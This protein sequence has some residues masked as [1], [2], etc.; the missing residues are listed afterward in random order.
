MAWARASDPE[1]ARRWTVAIIGDGG[2]TAGV[3]LEALN[4]LRALSLGPLLILLNDNQMS[5]SPNVGA[6]PAILSSGKAK[7]FFEAFDVDYIGP[8]D[9][10]DLQSLI[11]L[12]ESLKSRPPERPVILHALT[13]KG[14]G[15]LPAEE[16]PAFYHGISPI[17]QKLPESSQNSVSPSSSFSQVF[18]LALCKLAEHRPEIVAIT[19]AMPEGT[20]LTGFSQLHADRFFDVGIAEPHAVTFAAGLATQG[21]RPVVAIYSTFLQRGLDA[22]IHDVALQ[23]LPVVFAIDRAGLVGPDGPTHHGAFD[24]AYLG[25]IPGLQIYCPSVLSDVPDLLKKALDH[26]GPCAIRYPRGSA[27][28]TDSVSLTDGIRWHFQVEQP[29]AIVIALGAA[30]SKGLKV[31]ELLSPAERARCTFMSCV[32]AK[33]IPVSLIQV[34]RENP[35]ARVLVLEEGSIRG[36]FGQALISESGAR[37]GAWFLAGYPDRFIPHGSLSSLEEEAGI[38]IATLLQKLR[39]LLACI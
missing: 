23:D 10:H 17:P 22:I 25:A 24:L 31:R 33:P 3:A 13:Q 12:M 4:N 38:S 2:M 19:A 15:Y 37:S 34:L 5:I 27:S 20:G 14:K 8:V 16:S 35:R 7:E 21:Y 39:E 32:Q 28:A 18:G 30:S 36:G 6:I 1:D 9:G 26:P 29:S 11:G